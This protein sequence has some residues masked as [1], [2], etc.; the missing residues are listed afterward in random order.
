M[1][2]M[3]KL[4]KEIEGF[5]SERF[6]RDMIIALATVA[7]GAPHV[8]NVDA[9]YEDGTFYVITYA[10]SNKM[11][12]IAKNSAVAV[13]GEWFTGHGRG[14]NLGYFCKSENAEIAGKLRKAFSAWIDNGH[15]DFSDENTCILAIRLT[16]GL[17]YAGGGC[18]EIDFTK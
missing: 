9:Y 11:E 3:E 13:A 1:I 8:R 2:F 16:D 15:N 7:E 6:G 17:L 14:E 4:N 5:M 10:L 18:Y 12:Q